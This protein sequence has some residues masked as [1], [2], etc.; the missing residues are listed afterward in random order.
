M[1]AITNKTGA[2][3]SSDK[4]GISLIPRTSDVVAP[5]GHEAVRIRHVGGKRPF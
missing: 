2:L 4:A 5:L 1:N 3:K